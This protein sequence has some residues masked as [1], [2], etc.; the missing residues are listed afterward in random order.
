MSRY[1][2]VVRWSDS[3]DAYIAV[4]PELGGIYARVRQEAPEGVERRRRQDRVAY[5]AQAHDEYA[6]HPGPVPACGR[7]RA[8]FFPAR[9]RPERRHGRDARLR[10]SAEAL[11]PQSLPLRPPSPGCRS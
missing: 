5:R 6:P 2:S 3:D 4:C 1:S 9:R 11:H 10:L 7:E 8:R